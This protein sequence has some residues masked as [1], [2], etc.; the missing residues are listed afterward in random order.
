MIIFGILA[1]SINLETA[2]V[3][4]SIGMA[5]LAFF[6]VITFREDNFIPAH[7]EHLRQSL[8]LFKRGI[9][10]SR[11]DHEI[12][13]VFVATFLINAAFM[14][15]WLYPKRLVNLGFPHDPVFWYTALLVLSSMLGFFALQFVKI[16]IDKVSVAHR[17]YAFACFIGAIGLGILAFA[18]TAFIGSF[19]ALL[20]KGIADNVTRPISVI[21]VNRRTANDVRATVHSFLSQTESIGEVTGGF[22]LASIAQTNGIVTTLMAAGV[23]TALTGLIVVGSKRNIN[24]TN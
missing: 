22:V 24:K 8:S 19:G 11:K 15:A 1:W 10:L 18:S 14:V 12:F 4:S 3:I 2:I 6:V 23:L 21:W 7:E 16:H 9:T 13:L 20:T 5:V 17:F